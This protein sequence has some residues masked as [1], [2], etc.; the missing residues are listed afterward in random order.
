M[1]LYYLLPFMAIPLMGAACNP[2]KP[3]D[4]CAEVPV[5]K[6]YTIDMPERPQLMSSVTLQS[7]GLV[8]RAVSNDLSVLSEYA[9]KLENLLKSV[10]STAVTQVK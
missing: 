6:P 4:P 9:L 1:K 10:S 5:Y 3:R 2:E 7:E 8:V